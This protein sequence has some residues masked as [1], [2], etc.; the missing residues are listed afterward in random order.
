MQCVSCEIRRAKIAATALHLVGF[1]YEDITERLVRKYGNR[2]VVRN[3]AGASGFRMAIEREGSMY[4]FE[5]VVIHETLVR[6]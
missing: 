4:P 3:T 2:Y 6:Y 5:P 1:T